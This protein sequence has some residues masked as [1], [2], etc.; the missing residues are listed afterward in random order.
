MRHCEFGACRQGRIACTRRECGYDPTDESDM[1]CESTLG[2]FVTA[3]LWFAACGLFAA[4]IA[5]AAG[6]IHF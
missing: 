4:C 2:T 1:T 6:L 3:L 5:L